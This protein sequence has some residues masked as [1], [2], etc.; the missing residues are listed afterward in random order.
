[1]SLSSGLSASAVV[2]EEGEVQITINTE[3]AEG[4]VEPLRGRVFLPMPCHPRWMWS[5]ARQLPEAQV[6]MGLMGQREPQAI[7]LR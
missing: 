6:E 4:A 1:M 7:I 3:A 5:L 2:Q